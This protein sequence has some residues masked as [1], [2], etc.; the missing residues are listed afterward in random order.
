MTFLLLLTLLLLGAWVAA[1]G[2][3]VR[4]DG[5]GSRRPPRSHPDWWEGPAPG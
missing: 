5:L 1:L 2:R 3:T 4:H